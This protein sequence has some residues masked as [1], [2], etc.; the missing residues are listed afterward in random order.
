MERKFPLRFGY[1][2]VTFNEKIDVV[3]KILDGIKQ[4]S[5][6]YFDVIPDIVFVDK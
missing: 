6:C 4:V 1:S 2:N 5:G 3:K